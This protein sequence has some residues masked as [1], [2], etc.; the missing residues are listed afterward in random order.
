MTKA[1]Y[2][3]VDFQGEGGSRMLSTFDGMLEA[4]HWCETL[5]AERKGDVIRAHVDKCPPGEMVWDWTPSAPLGV[6]GVRDTIIV[7]YPWFDPGGRSILALCSPMIKLGSRSDS[8]TFR[9]SCVTCTD[10]RALFPSKYGR[11]R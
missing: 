4:V 11:G 1:Y 9:K 8:W 3:Y 6:T 2:G 7:H 10:C 5:I